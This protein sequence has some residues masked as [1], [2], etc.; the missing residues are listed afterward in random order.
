MITR[1]FLRD[2]K[3]VGREKCLLADLQYYKYM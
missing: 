2:S 1:I 3:V